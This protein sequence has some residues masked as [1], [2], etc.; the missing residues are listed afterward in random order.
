MEGKKPQRSAKEP[1]RS[2]RKCRKGRDEA[3]QRKRWE[4]R[5]GSRWT[6][7]LHL[8]PVKRFSLKTFAPTI[9]KKKQQ[10]KQQRKQRRRR[11]QQQG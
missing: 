11:Q 9:L 1:L 5:E 7:R 4:E 3:V 2:P 6:K 8:L 10:Q